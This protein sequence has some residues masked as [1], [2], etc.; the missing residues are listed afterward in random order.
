FL[1]TNK[2]VV[3][4]SYVSLFQSLKGKIVIPCSPPDQFDKSGFVIISTTNGRTVYESNELSIT[5]LKTI[6]AEGLTNEI[7]INKRN[8]SE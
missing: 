7:I 1:K 2:Q 4:T 6:E 5:V 8:G 3:Y